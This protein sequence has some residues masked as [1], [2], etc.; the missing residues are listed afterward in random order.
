LAD[1]TLAVFVQTIAG[2]EKALAHTCAQLE[3]SD[4]GTDYTVLTGE[5]GKSAREH[6]LAVLDVMGSS[7]ADLVLRL[8]DDID[9]AAHMRHNLT[10]WRELHDPRF[11]LGWAFSPGGVRTI[12]DYWHQR[13]GTS[14]WVSAPYGYSQAVLA[15]K[16]DLEAL[17]AACTAWCAKT[18]GDAGQDLC[19]SA[20]AVAIGKLVCIHAPSQVEHRLDFGT[21]LK[22]PPNPLYGTSRGEFAK[23]AQWKRPA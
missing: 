16:R 9:V 21:T 22:H 23:F 12:I 2:R 14:K 11:G 3:A 18:P 8:E 15:W 10:H 1:P 19:L 5:P 7:D 4:V 6:L 13:P 17:R 20:A